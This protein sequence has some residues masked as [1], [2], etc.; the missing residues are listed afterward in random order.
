MGYNHHSTLPFLV[1]YAIFGVLHELAHLATA[2]WLLNQTSGSP[3]TRLGVGAM[4]DAALRA[5][6][7][8]YSLIEVNNEQAREARLIVHAGWIFSLSLAIVCHLLHILARNRQE[9][10]SHHVM[11]A[12]RNHGKNIF[13]HPALPMAAYITAIEAIVTD[14]LGFTPIHPYLQD[15]TRLICFC[16]NF[17]VLLLNPSWLSIDGGR[18]ALDILEKMVNVTMMR[19]TF[20]FTRDLIC[21][22]CITYTVH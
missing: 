16:G 7:G 10:S 15:S 18:T 14:L 5:A 12:T 21:A 13:L 19:G 4:L 6:L 22:Y 3:P 20:P 9:I 17:G 11:Q 2:S 1:A 8:R